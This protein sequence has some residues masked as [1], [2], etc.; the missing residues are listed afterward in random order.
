MRFY[1]KVE[2]GSTVNVPQKASGSQVGDII[3][4]AGLSLVTI[5]ASVLVAKVVTNF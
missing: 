4:Q 3:K 1:P 5:V 2:E